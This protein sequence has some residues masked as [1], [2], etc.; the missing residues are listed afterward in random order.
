MPT[1]DLHS[2]KLLIIIKFYLENHSNFLKTDCVRVSEMHECSNSTSSP[3]VRMHW[4][5]AISKRDNRNDQAH[6]L[7]GKSSFTY[8]CI[9]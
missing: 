5:E 8:P 1:Q 6:R 2:H 7:L 4:R 9:Y 3:H